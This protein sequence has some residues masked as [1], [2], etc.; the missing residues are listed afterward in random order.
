MTKKCTRKF[1]IHTRDFEV[2]HFLECKCNLGVITQKVE[3][4][5]GFE[6]HTY[7]CESVSAFR[8]YTYTRESASAFRVYTRTQRAVLG[9]MTSESEFRLD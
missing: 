7:T 6:T 9:A 4:A 5:C 2:W 1:R 8:I 3:S